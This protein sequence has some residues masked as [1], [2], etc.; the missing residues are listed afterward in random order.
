[1]TFSKANR[2]LQRLGIK[3]GHKESPGGVC[4]CWFF[5]GCFFFLRGWYC[6]WAFVVGL[7]F[8]GHDVQKNW[9]KSKWY[10]LKYKKMFIYEKWRF[11]YIYSTHGDFR[12]FTVPIENH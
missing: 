12:T 3:F 9:L 5:F 2:D 11:P 6:F 4:F 8:L 10:R 7:L 1:M